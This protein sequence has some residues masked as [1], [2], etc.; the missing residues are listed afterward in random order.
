MWDLIGASGH[1][2]TQSPR[3]NADSSVRSTKDSQA[4]SR[5]GVYV[6]LLGSR[7]RGT[8]T[9]PI[10]NKQ[11]SLCSTSISTDIKYIHNIYNIH[12]ISQVNLKLQVGLPRKPLR[13]PGLK[14]SPPLG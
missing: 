4:S 6:V 8:E 1:K 9:G 10:G 14:V 13:S 2:R 3:F 5:S 7:S 11:S 12:K